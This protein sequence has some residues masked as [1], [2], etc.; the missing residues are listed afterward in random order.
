MSVIENSY[1]PHW[2]SV[3]G[4]AIFFDAEELPRY[5]LNVIGLRLTLLVGS[6]T[7]R[8]DRSA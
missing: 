6:R 3:G 8:A 7:C 5:S 4:A 1:E 2:L